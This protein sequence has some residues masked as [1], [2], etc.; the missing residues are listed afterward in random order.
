MKK[1]STNAVITDWV[2]TRRFKMSAWLIAFGLLMLL[3]IVVY[4]IENHSLVSASGKQA[5]SDSIPGATNGGANDS[6]DKTGQRSLSEA[7][8]AARYS[9][10][11]VKHA[12]IPKDEGAFQAHN[13]QQGYSTYFA[14]DEVDLVYREEHENWRVGM[15]L[16]GYG[17]DPSESGVISSN[18]TVSSHPV[19]DTWATAQQRIE[20]HWRSENKTS[21]DYPTVVEWYENNPEGLE[22]GFTIS[23]SPASRPAHS[24]SLRLVLQLDGDLKPLPQQDQQALAFVKKTGGSTVLN[25]GNLKAIDAVGKQL[26]S[27]MELRGDELSLVVDDHDAVYPVTIDPLFT[28]TKKVTAPDPTQT[29]DFGSGVAIDGDTLVVGAVS[30]FTSQQGSAYIFERNQGGADNWSLVKELLAPDGVFGDGFGWS[31]AISK[32]TV[33]IAANRKKVGF[34]TQQGSVYVYERNSGGANNWGLVKELTASDAEAN[35]NFGWALDVDGDSAIV[36]MANHH[37]NDTITT[38]AAY[39]FDRNAG[40]PNNWGEVKRI[41]R[42]DNQDDWAGYSVG[43]SGDTA[44]I[45]APKHVNFATSTIGSAY[46]V[47]RNEGGPNNWGIEKKLN[48]GLLFV[49]NTFFGVAVSIDSDRLVVGAGQENIPGETTENAAYVFDRNEAGSNNW[50]LVKKVVASDDVS[51]N[52]FALSL[53]I[54]GDSLVV[55]ARGAPIGANTQRGAVYVYKQNT[56]GAD[57]WGQEKKV[58]AADGASGD[59][60]GWSVALDGKTL[61]VGAPLDTVD[62]H[63]S[64]FCLSFQE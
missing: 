54:S 45:G 14:S 55:G 62:Y 2:K 41:T 13:P 52:A 39:I 4:R 37:N 12:P 51:G 7:I 57:N 29:A 8:R 20:K 28:Q 36:G 21:V 26:V 18:T 24:H 33:M 17:W 27:R 15:K 30:G 43:I 56:G 47:E 6:L 60:F 34:N 25:Y 32:D 10:N 49:N 35:D 3:T 22:Q 48:S 53:A 50:G 64:R 46:V 38:S 19:S 59:L 44:I 5:M 11:W 58:I 42:T 31:V 16:I 40:G 1:F 61:V 9:I 63:R 23:A